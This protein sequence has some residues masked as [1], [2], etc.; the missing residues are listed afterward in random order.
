MNNALANELK[1]RLMD[2]YADTKFAF[3]IMVIAKEENW[4]QV[5]Q[6]LNHSPD[7]SKDK[8]TIAVVTLKQI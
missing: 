3:Q 5:L 4:E 2:M 8:L 1:T 6:M 7:I